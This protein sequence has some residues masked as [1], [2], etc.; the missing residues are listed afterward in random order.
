MPEYDVS[1]LEMEDCG[2]M[3]GSIAELGEGAGRITWNNS[4]QMGKAHPLVTEED[5][6]EIRDYYR[7]FGAWDDEEIDAWTLED[8]NGMVTQEAAAAFREYERFDSYEEYQTAAEA[9]QVSGNLYR[10]D[11]GRWWI[12]ICL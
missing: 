1:H 4:V 3:S 6:D 7:E 9:G 10:D 11:S 2:M 5:A 12:N 8:L